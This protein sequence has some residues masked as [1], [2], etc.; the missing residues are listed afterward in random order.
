[1]NR[2]KRTSNIGTPALVLML[3]A[4]VILSSGGISYAVLKN[5]QITVR[6]EISKVQKRMDE[7]RVSI[8]LHQSDVDDLLSYYR[9]REQL[10]EMGSPLREIHRVEVYREPG[11][12]P[13][14][15][16]VIASRE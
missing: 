14:A 9:L 6:R 11:E 5:R 3:I 7:H 8:T 4:L 12:V 2:K 15:D 10:A 1:M 16:G 13:G